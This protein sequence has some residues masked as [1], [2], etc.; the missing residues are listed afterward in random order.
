MAGT[1][2]VFSETRIARVVKSERPEVLMKAMVGGRVGACDVVLRVRDLMRILLR[3][4]VEQSNS[5]KCYVEKM[6]GR[7]PMYGHVNRATTSLPCSMHGRLDRVR[8]GSSAL[9]MG[10]FRSKQCTS[11]P[12]LDCSDRRG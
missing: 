11:R 6:L 5:L 2:V 9:R 10:F 7:E 12:S 1:E 8:E 4:Y 3:Y